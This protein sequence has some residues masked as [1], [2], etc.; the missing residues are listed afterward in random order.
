[1]RLR[2]PELNALLG[3]L[4]WQA[5]HELNDISDYIWKSPRLLTHEKTL[6]QQKLE[7]YFPDGGRT[8]EIRRHYESV[9]LN[10]TFPRLIAVGNLFSTLSVFENYVLLLLNLLQEHS[11]TLPKHESS[12]G[13]AAHLKAAK[14]YGAA[15]YDAKYYEQVCVAI[16][17]RNCL[18]HAKGLLAAFRSG[19]ALKTQI[20]QCK[21]LCSDDRKR[22]AVRGK[23]LGSDL[24]SIEQ[25]ELGEQL[26]ITNEYSHHVCFY[27]REYFCALCGTLNPNTALRPAIH[28]IDPR[29]LAGKLSYKGPIM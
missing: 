21:F 5:F 18:M 13:V 23:S 19:E 25:A 17:I 26:A 9:K 7:T 11:T 24:V 22:R 8:A 4:E 12:Q 14:V 29:E 16:S 28:E 1:M 3:K 15:P 10:E 2:N 20:K 6:E 27:L